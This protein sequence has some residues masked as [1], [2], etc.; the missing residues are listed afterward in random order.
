MSNDSMPKSPA[1][2]FGDKASDIS[3][4]HMRRRDECDAVILTKPGVE[5]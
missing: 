3:V 5:K 2:T 1:A 4:V